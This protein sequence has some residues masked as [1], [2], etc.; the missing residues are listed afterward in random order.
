MDE[1]SRT[2]PLGLKCLNLKSSG[3]FHA[4]FIP[5]EYVK[6]KDR[7][8][9]Y[10]KKS[11]AL[12]VI[13]EH[14][15]GRLKTFK[16]Y[17]EA[18]KYAL[19][20]LEDSNCTVKKSP[21]VPKIRAKEPEEAP[22]RVF[23]APSKSDLTNFKKVITLGD[24]EGVKNTVWE[25]PR[26]LVSGGD[27]PVI[28]KEGWRYNALHI[29]VMETRMNKAEMCETILNTVGNV[30]F[31]K[32]LDGDQKDR[33]YLNRAQI[34][35]DLYLNMPEK[36]QNETPLHFAAKFGYRDV[37]K[38][39]ISYAQCMKN[40]RNKD[41]KTPMD[42]ICSRCQQ[43]DES[44]TKDIKRLLDE[45]FYVPVLRS[46]DNTL[47]PSIGEPFSPMSPPNF[48][49]DPMSPRVEVRAFAG[50]MSKD[51]ATEFRRKWKTPPRIANSY[52]K[53]DVSLNDSLEVPS[54]P[55]ASTSMR[56][57]DSEKGLER[58]GRELAKEYH[59][60]WKEYWPFLDDFADMRHP[61]G[62]AKLERFLNERFNDQLASNKEGTKYVESTPKKVSEIGTL[63]DLKVLCSRLD[64][65]HLKNGEED[66]GWSDGDEFLTPPPSPVAT[67][68]ED[69]F[70][71]DEGVPL[72]IEGKVPSKVDHAVFN[73]LPAA[74][75]P[76]FPITYPSIYRWRHDV[77]LFV[78]RHGLGS[79][80]CVKSI[81]RRLLQTPERVQRSRP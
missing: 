74:L 33:C 25:N 1:S 58:V 17:V 8:H 48:N 18:E 16:S 9:V 54:S 55:M 73:A 60:P 42:I 27:T 75:D 50:P 41:K 15:F 30:D 4:V 77:Q 70:V 46:D 63:N 59:V 51:E 36:R 45:Q 19:H 81:R 28:L 35:Q 47:Q 69:M 64:A 26:Y 21:A 31:L 10:Q 61:E 79:D 24:V 11:E 7:I 72:F 2:G 34:L 43:A 37:V 65:L 3:E 5:S 14:K 49:A 62:L 29:T 38:V 66:Q 13:K 68:N 53:R 56:L 57:H 44:L 67:N 6:V 71:P 23:E 32:L 12:A 40:V 20:G 76:L 78:R 39:L 80:A 52:N 22:M